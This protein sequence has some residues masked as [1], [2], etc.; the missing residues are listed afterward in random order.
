MV[1]TERNLKHFL[2]FVFNYKCPPNRPDPPRALDE[3]KKILRRGCEK[4]EDY[5]FVWKL[6][7]ASYLL[8]RPQR[9][10]QVDLTS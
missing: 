5:E 4:F 1:I 9:F 2:E 7:L 8:E 10:Q 3:Y 6:K